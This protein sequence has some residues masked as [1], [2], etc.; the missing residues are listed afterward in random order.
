MKLLYFDYSYLFRKIVWHIISKCRR[1]VRRNRRLNLHFLMLEEIIA[2]YFPASCNEFYNKWK[3]IPEK[4]ISY[5]FQN[6]DLSKI[7]KAVVVGA[8]AI[9][10]TAIILAKKTNKT[11]YL[12]EKNHIASFISSN[13]LRRFNFNNVKVIKKSGQHYDGYVNSLIIISLQTVGKQRV[14]EHILSYKS[15]NNIIVV[16][17]PLTEYNC[18]YESISLDGLNYKTVRHTQILESIILEN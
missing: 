4:E 14:F 18:F 17:Q 1:F 16:R 11:V 2:S 3:E 6:H 5:L 9:P 12:I 7:D 10:Y 15:Y 8:G 13:V